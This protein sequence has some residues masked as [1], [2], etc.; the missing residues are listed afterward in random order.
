MEPRRNFPR[1]PPLLFPEGHTECSAAY[2]ANLALSFPISFFILSSFS[3]VASELSSS[4]MC[5]AVA[6]EGLV[7]LENKMYPDNVMMIIVIGVM[8]VLMPKT[9]KS[10]VRNGRSMVSSSAARAVLTTTALRN[11]RT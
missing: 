5:D 4:R 9:T 7:R 6:V 1:L 11:T 10:L 3:L 8:G 2:F